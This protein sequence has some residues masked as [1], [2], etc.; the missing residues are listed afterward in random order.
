MTCNPGERYLAGG[1]AVEAL[2]VNGLSEA[3]ISAAPS[4]ETVAAELHDRLA[5]IQARTGCGMELRAYNS[6]FDQPFLGAQPWNLHGPWGACIMEGASSILNPDGKWLK[7]RESL[8][9]LGLARAGPMHNAEAD[10]HAALLVHEA[11]AD[12]KPTRMVAGIRLPDA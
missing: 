11:L 3:L 5:K 7:L 4:A 12:F 1:R 6:K 8:S 10:A 2:R 9:L